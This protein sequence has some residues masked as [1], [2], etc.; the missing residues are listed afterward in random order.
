MI[1]HTVSRSHSKLRGLISGFCYMCSYF[2]FNLARRKNKT[3]SETNLLQPVDFLLLSIF[4]CCN[5]LTANFRKGYIRQTCLFLY[6][7]Q[8]LSICYCIYFCV[9]HFYTITNSKLAWHRNSEYLRICAPGGF[10]TRVEN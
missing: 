8:P 9:L 3:V 7:L 4:N 1:R 6:P 5:V 2:L 10:D